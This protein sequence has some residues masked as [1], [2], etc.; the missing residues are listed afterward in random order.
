M[1]YNEPKAYVV[2]Y[3]HFPDKHKVVFR[4]LLN[5]TKYTRKKT[6]KSTFPK[7]RRLLFEALEASRSDEYTGGRRKKTLKEAMKRTG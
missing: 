1:C 4:G 3:Y 6:K 2:V 7:N 5:W